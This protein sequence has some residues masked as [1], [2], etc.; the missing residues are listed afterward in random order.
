M[1]IFYLTGFNKRI[2]KNVEIFLSLDS[3]SKQLFQGLDLCR[4]AIE[5]K[6]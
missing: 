4:K 5:W 2:S 1:V 3:S 6:A